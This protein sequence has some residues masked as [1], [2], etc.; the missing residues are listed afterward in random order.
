MAF[1]TLL[2]TIMIFAAQGQGEKILTNAD[3]LEL[4]EAGLS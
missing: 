4:I 2:I 1:S 3:V